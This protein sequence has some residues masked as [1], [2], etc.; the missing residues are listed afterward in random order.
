MK[1]CNLEKNE[2]P[3]AILFFVKKIKEGLEK[4]CWNYDKALGECVYLV[5]QE[6][7]YC[8]DVNKI[9]EKIFSN[10]NW[11]CKMIYYSKGE[12]GFYY[13][14]FQMRKKR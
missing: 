12:K 9:I 3:K 8:Y 13:Y 7:S 1:K 4:K 5:T 10:K 14:T 6:F 2:I 11:E